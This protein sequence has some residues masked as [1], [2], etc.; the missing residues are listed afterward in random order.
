MSVCVYCALLCVYV[1]AAADDLPQPGVIY[2][3][4][5]PLDA[6]TLRTKNPVAVVR[7][8]EGNRE[9]RPG[10]HLIVFQT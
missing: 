4:Q 5:F 2:V 1:R 10:G 6:S 7:E 3:H 9:G 8:K